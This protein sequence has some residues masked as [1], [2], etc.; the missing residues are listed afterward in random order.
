MARADLAGEGAFLLVDS[1]L[2]TERDRTASQRLADG[3]RY[4]NGGQTATRTRRSSPRPRDDRLGQLLAR[5]RVLVY[6]FQLPATNLVRMCV[7][8]RLAA[9]RCVDARVLT[10]AREARG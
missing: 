1:V 8:L 4:G 5:R 9:S 7:V 2:R 3:I 10:S 6:I